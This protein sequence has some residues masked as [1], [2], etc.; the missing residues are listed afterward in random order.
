MSNKINFG[1]KEV[2]REEKTS[3]VNNVFSSV[4]ENYDLMNDIMS[5]GLHRIWKQYF[6]TIINIQ[7]NQNVLDLAAGTADISRL[8]LKQNSKTFNLTMCDINEKIL[9]AGR[10]K[11]VDYG[12]VSNF[13]TI[14][15]DAQNLPFEE[16]YFHHVTCSFGIRNTS[17]I[18]D[19]LNSI[20]R[21]LKPGGSLNILEFSKPNNFLSGVY[22]LYLNKFIPKI[23]GIVAE[24]E[25]SYRY[26][27]ESIQLHPS[28][29][30]MID[31]M[32][33]VGYRKCQYY[34]LTSGIVAVH[35]GYKI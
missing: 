26:L 32:E 16:N 12:Y 20:Y 4:T 1:K 14:V 33:K 10:D 6:T 25:G 9:R 22:D 31:K 17:S 23:G 24:D 19:A 5:F 30:E 28:Q 34:N 27:A 2:S 29:K 11:L 3:L 21:V 7:N 13:K 8:L 15:G 35:K 18:D